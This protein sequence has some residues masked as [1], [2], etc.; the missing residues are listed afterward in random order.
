VESG[1]YSDARAAEYLTTVLRERR[2]RIGRYW[3]KKAG[4]LDNFRATASPAGTV[5]EFA[6]MLVESGFAEPAQREYRYRV[7]GRGTAA[8]WATA[9]HGAVAFTAGQDQRDARIELQV[10]HSGEREWSPSVTVFMARA[11]SAWQVAGWS[12]D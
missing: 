11:G 3:Y 10:R 5:L 12:R 4:A 6:D 8:A 7:L 1:R 2:D 9:Q